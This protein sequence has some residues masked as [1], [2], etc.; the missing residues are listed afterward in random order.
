MI[1]SP[2]PKRKR[3]RPPIEGLTQRRQDEILSVATLVFARTGYS[4]TD[5]QVVADKMGVGKGTLYRYFPS[6]KHMFQAALERVLEGMKTVVDAAAA[7]QEDPLEQLY[8]VV[9]AYLGYFDD[10][11]EY[12]E[13]LIQERA[14][15][16]D[17][18]RSSY[19]EHR[20]GRIARWHDFYRN[21]IRE[22]RVRDI[23]VERITDVLSNACYGA[24]FTNYFTGHEK[25]LAEQAEDILDV[26]FHGL[27]TA[28]G[29]A[30]HRQRGSGGR[31]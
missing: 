14:E 1:E 27:L 18:R 28:Q 20:S 19:F 5:L 11:P 3:G 23:P 15:F 4:C 24:M 2:I 30:S 9:R 6:K 16:R 7:E 17:R 21:L 10:H 13:L 8:A 22:G 12:V 31:S 25:S 29:R 26:V